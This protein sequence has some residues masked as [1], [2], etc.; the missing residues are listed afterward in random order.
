LKIVENK[1]LKERIEQKIKETKELKE[2]ILNKFDAKV[3]ELDK[4]K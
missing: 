4:N 3:D 1:K 2:K